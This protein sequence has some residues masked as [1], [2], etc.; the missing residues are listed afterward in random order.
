MNQIEALFAKS[1]RRL[2]QGDAAGARKGLLKVVK[3]SPG[4]AVAW[5]NLGLC[6]QHLN[7]HAKAVGA[8][9][10]VVGIKP[11]FV[12]GWVNL[13]LSQKALDRTQDAA[14]SVE[15]ALGLDP[16]HPRALNLKGT[17]A[18][19]SGDADTARSCFE[20]SLVVQPDNEDA[21]FNLAGL[22]VEM[23]DNE[24]AL[25][26]AQSLS[27]RQPGNM[28]YDQLRAR[29]LMGLRR[30][31]EALDIIKDLEERD[32][33]EPSVMRLG[34]SFREVIRDHFG[35]IDAVERIIEKGAADASVWNSLGSA[36][37]QL[38]SIEKA[39]GYYENA[40]RM[41]PTSAEYENN[42]GLAVSSLGRKAEAEQH[43]RRSLELDPKHAEAWR[44]LTAMKRFEST[45]DPDA[46]TIKALWDE[47]AD[48]FTMTKLSFA[49]GKVYDDCGEYD[50]AF[51]TYARGNELKFQDSRIDLVKYFAHMER[52]PR[53]FDRPPVATAK[54]RTEIQPIFI[55]GMPRSGTTLVEQII[56]RHPSVYG[57]GELPC[58]E[59]AIGRIEKRSRPQRVYPEDFWDVPESSFSTEA[60]EYENWVK[61]LHDID[62]PYVTDKMP[63]NFVH[64]WLIKAMFPDAPIVHCQRHPLDVITSNYFQ[65]YGSDISFVYDLEALTTYYVRYFRL[66]AHWTKVFGAA[67]THVRYEELIEDHDAQTRRLVSE[68][69]LPWDDACLD[70]RRSET[71]VR[72]ASIWQVR[73]G[74][75]K[76]SRARWRHYESQLAPA[77]EMLVN[78]G[79]L[80][81]RG[82]YTY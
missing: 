4:S 44:N 16:D 73:Q 59:R 75:Y 1:A 67:I 54:A 53:V 9:G 74:I 8:Y 25:E 50:K 78:E 55:L 31:E 29:A 6:H 71:A 2:Q 52:F 76:T 10:K 36:Y 40:V 14:A 47:G 48:D 12:D 15:R 27:L 66:M 7:E 62:T 38:D 69:G 28:Q 46:R 5:Y 61:R 39:K 77:I 30:F 49:L 43:Y 68:I 19:E 35:A 42:L 18:A 26:I 72:T 58:I 70:P 51:E 17:L 23:R 3:Q 32:P 63:F 41:D 22:L 64:V 65:L 33:D 79:I 80:N 82:Q 57:C 21:S 45:D 20:A 81:P 11:D 34:L 56:A 24:R 37:F 60:L 13:G